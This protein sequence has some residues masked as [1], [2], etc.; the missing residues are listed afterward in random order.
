[1]SVEKSH[2]TVSKCMRWHEETTLHMESRETEREKENEKKTCT[3]IRDR[4]DCGC[5][6]VHFS[7]SFSSETMKCENPGKCTQKH[8]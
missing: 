2:K 3:R 7:C 5:G 1:M 6:V 4:E 8:D